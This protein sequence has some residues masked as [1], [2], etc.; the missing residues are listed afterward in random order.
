MGWCGIIQLHDFLIVILATLALRLVRENGG[1]LMGN[2]SDGFDSQP[3]EKKPLAAVN[4]AMDI[5][6]D[7]LIHYGAGLL[8]L[9]FGSR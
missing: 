9:P 8:A 6:R 5:L 1:A 3:K 7:S 4:V 2:D